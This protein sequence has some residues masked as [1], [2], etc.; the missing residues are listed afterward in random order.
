MNIYFTIYTTNALFLIIDGKK[1]FQMKN[2]LIRMFLAN[3]V[4][5]VESILCATTF[6]YIEEYI[7]RKGAYP[8]ATMK[9]KKISILNT[10]YVILVQNITKGVISY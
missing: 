9:T 7:V 4:I 6:L 8:I 5:I 3:Y 1:Y 10:I 2:L